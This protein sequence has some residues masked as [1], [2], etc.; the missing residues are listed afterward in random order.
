M[1]RKLE[2]RRNKRWL[3]AIA[4]AG[5]TLLVLLF[6]LREAGTDEGS[7]AHAVITGIA[8]VVGAVLLSWLMLWAVR[9]RTWNP[10]LTPSN[11]VMG[12]IYAT[13]GVVYS[14]IFAF[15]VVTTWQ[16]FEEARSLEDAESHAVADLF[17]LLPGLPAS[18]QEAARSTL[19]EYAQTAIEVEWPR[20][21]DGDST[22]SAT[23]V[24]LDRLWQIYGGAQSQA[25]AQSA[26][27]SEDIERLA[28]L[29][30]IRRER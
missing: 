16:Q 26:F 23:A 13:I 6:T 14:V 9:E 18:E 1:D 29:G 3:L 28:D 12:F 22:G 17:R 11:E 8:V 5:L 15:V 19:T 20:M 30:G 24:L 10:E 21:A 2:W 25:T 4:G 27:Y 7:V